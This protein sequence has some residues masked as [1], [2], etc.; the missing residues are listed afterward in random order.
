MILAVLRPSPCGC[1]P[2][3]RASRFPHPIICSYQTRKKARPS[4]RVTAYRL[5]AREAETGWSAGP[6]PKAA[7]RGSRR[8]RET[9]TRLRVPV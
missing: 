3:R 5:S 2:A 8:L 4:R 1:G 7:S 9:T 6:S